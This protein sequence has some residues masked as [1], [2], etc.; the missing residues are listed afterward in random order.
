MSWGTLVLACQRLHRRVDIILR[1]DVTIRHFRADVVSELW[2]C[3][4]R[5]GK[6]RGEIQA[7]LRHLSKRC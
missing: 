3:D 7:I 6:A 5:V 1:D 4:G 2:L